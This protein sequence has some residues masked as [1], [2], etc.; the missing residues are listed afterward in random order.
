M[1]SKLKIDVSISLGRGSS[2]KGNFL[3]LVVNL[4][5]RHCLIIPYVY[6]QVLGGLDRAAV[7]IPYVDGAIGVLKAKLSIDGLIWWAE[8]HLGISGKRSLLCFGQH[9]FHCSNGKRHGGYQFLDCHLSQHH[10]L[11]GDSIADLSF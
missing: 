11:A 9:G 5:L 2:Q 1:S 3:K 8:F 7:H 10:N 6:R 4:I